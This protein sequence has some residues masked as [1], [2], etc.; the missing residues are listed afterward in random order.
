MIL[1]RSIEGCRGCTTRSG[2]CPPVLSR[3]RIVVSLSGLH[4]EY[5]GS[6]PAGDTVTVV[7]LVSAA[8]CESADTDSS[9]VSHLGDRI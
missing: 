9:S 8:D 4:P 6:T 7:Q 3:H 1:N 2:T 5:V